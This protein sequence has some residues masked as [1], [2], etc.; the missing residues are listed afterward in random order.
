ME[1]PSPDP[2]SR[3]AP[4]KGVPPPGFALLIYHLYFFLAG[5]SPFGQVP[6]I[7]TPDGKVLGQSFAIMKYICREAGQSD[8][9][10]V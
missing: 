6:F 7:I 3:S 8:M 4:S 9:Y 5:R 1:P 2:S 10:V